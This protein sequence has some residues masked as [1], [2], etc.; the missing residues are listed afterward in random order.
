MLRRVLIVD[1]EQNVRRT[2]AV[3]LRL[4]GFEAEEAPGSEAAMALLAAKTFDV[5]LLDLMLPEVNGLDL[6][7][8]I[9][10]RYPGVCVI[11][12]SGYHLSERQVERADAGISAFLPK[13]FLI[14]EAVR[15]CNEILGDHR[16]RAVG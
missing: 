7:R 15:V 13:P 14:E 16:Q 3:G 5:A 6:A 12:M 4:S 2:L 1:D 10:D 11:L 9:H 8:W